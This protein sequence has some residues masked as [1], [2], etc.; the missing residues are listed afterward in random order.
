MHYGILSKTDESSHSERLGYI[1]PSHE[2]F[3][4]S[5]VLADCANQLFR[6]S[7][8]G[9]EGGVFFTATMLNRKEAKTGQGKNSL[10]EIKDF[11]LLKS[12]VQFCHCF[13]KKY[14][15]NPNYDN[16]PALL[17]SADWKKKQNYV[18]SLVEAALK[19]LLPYFK[20]CSTDDP[21]LDDHPL[22]DGRRDGLF[23]RTN[24]TLESSPVRNKTLEPKSLLS[25]GTDGATTSNSSTSAQSTLNFKC[26]NCTFSSKYRSL[27][28]EHKKNCI[29]L[30]QNQEEGR[31]TDL[32]GSEKEEDMFWNYKCNEFFM[33]A[34][35]AASTVFEKYGDG[36]GY[37]IL[38]KI[39]LPIFY[40]LKHSNYSNSIHR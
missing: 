34:L 19:D 28:L 5:M 12:E 20:D 4:Q 30:D 26:A 36:L 38:N 23:R 1:L 37:Y 3:H 32:N 15:F 18:Y 8:R 40:G 24:S 10:D 35:F 14:N 11:M 39:L 6:E 22:Q 25:H 21:H 29:S 13:L 16:T 17:K 9:L 27:I 33:D 7:S 2:Y 31:S